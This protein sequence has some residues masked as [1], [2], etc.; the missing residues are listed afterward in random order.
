MFPVAQWGVRHKSNTFLEGWR[1]PV[2]IPPTLILPHKEGGDIPFGARP[3][4]EVNVRGAV[5]GCLGEIVR[6]AGWR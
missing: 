2:G 3:T 6:V 1:L 5:W 4:K